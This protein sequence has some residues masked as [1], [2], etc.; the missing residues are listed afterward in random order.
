MPIVPSPL[1]TN[2]PCNDATSI[3]RNAARSVCTGL[4]RSA[5]TLPRT[6]PTPKP[7][8]MIPQLVAPS[9]SVCAIDGPSTNTDGR[10]STW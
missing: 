10:T 1:A 3:A 6:A 5:S 2:A 7:A 8:V 4:R 9:R